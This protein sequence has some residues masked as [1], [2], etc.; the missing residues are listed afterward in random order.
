MRVNLVLLLTLSPPIGS[1]PAGGLS[2]ALAVIFDCY[3]RLSGPPLVRCHPYKRN[4]RRRSGR[5]R[6]ARAPRRRHWRRLARW[7][8]RTAAV[9]DPEGD[10]GRRIGAVLL[11]VGDEVARPEL[12]LCDPRPGFLLLVGVAR[13]RAAEPRGT[14]CARGRSSRSRARSSRPRDTACR[15]SGAPARPGSPATPASSSSRTQPGSRRRYEC[16]PTRRALLDRHGLAAEELRHPLGVA[17][18]LRA[19]G[20][21]VDRAQDVHG[22]RSVPSTSSLRKAGY[23]PELPD[24]DERVALLDNVRRL[25]LRSPAQARA[26]SRSP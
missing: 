11:A 26:G 8:G 19:H 2:G 23:C 7:S 10:M 9:A 22:A 1:Q 21:D 24:S 4:S 6:Q 13:Y 18:R 15:G 20:S 25:Q 14:T 5:A 16:G 3:R 12:L 17:A